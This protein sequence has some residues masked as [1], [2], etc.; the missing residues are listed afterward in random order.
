MNGKTANNKARHSSYKPQ[1]ALGRSSALPQLCC[2]K[3]IDKNLVHYSI[4]TNECSH[5]QIVITPLI[6]DNLVVIAP[7]NH[8]FLGQLPAIDLKELKDSKFIL[9]GPDNYMRHLCVSAC[10]AADL[11]RI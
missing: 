8:S 4:Y 1:Q 10:K 2:K 5:P 9:Q 6:E 7:K 11:Y 3:I